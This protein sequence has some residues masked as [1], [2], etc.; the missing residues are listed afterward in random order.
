MTPLK[1]GKRTK[2]RRMGDADTRAV[3][4][5]TAGY[6]KQDMECQLDVC[7]DTTGHMNPSRDRKMSLKT[8][9]M[10]FDNM[11]GKFDTV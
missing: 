2:T 10:F 9:N 11:C 3:Y 1:T 4:I 8:W 6:R 5:G 7:H